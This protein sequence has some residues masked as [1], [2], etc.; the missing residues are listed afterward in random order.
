MWLKTF[1]VQS[2][3]PSLRTAPGKTGSKNK[4]LSS[5]IA[6]RKHCFYVKCHYDGRKTQPRFNFLYLN[7]HM[8]WISHSWKAFSMPTLHLILSPTAWPPSHTPA[9]PFF[10]LSLNSQASLHRQT[11]TPWKSSQVSLKHVPSA[12]F[13]NLRDLRWPLK[14]SNPPLTSSCHIFFL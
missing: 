7:G 13:I 6:P 5:S 4:T 9:T 2:N 8:H 3:E 12:L 14:Q 1:T 10:F 11:L